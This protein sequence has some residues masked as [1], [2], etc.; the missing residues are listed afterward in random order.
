MFAKARVIQ[1]N[2]GNSRWPHITLQAKGRRQA[3]PLVPRMDQVLVDLV[4]KFPADGT[5]EVLRTQLAPHLSKQL[6]SACVK[7]KLKP[8]GRPSD[9]ASKATY[10]DLLCKY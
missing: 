2:G 4:N 5:E 6:R 9:G 10:I 7:L 3:L 1:A 8:Q